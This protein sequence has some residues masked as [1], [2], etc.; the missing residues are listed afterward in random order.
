YTDVINLIQELLEACINAEH[1]Y[2]EEMEK[3]KMKLEENKL[4]EQS[5]RQLSEQSKKAM[6]AMS[7]QMEEAQDAYKKAMDS[8]PSGWEMI[9]MD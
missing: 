6:E 9:G 3:V 2:G 5:A 4:R 1:F 8:L 7:K